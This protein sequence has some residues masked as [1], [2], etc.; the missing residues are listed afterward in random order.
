MEEF[1]NALANLDWN[2]NLANNEFAWAAVVGG[3]LMFARSLPSILRMWA[4]RVF[5][6][7]ITACSE[8]N[9]VF[10]S[11]NAWVV[12]HNIRRYSNNFRIIEYHEDDTSTNRRTKEASN[13]ADENKFEGAWESNG[14]IWAVAPSFGKHLIVVDGIPVVVDRTQEERVSFQDSRR[15]ENMTAWL[16]RSKF[17]LNK[18][19]AQIHAMNEAPQDEVQISL[20]NS[21]EPRSFAVSKVNGNMLVYRDDAFSSVLE[22][23]RTFLDSRER[24]KELN[25]HW[26]RG[27]GFFGPPG[28]G[29]TSMILALASHLGVGIHKFSLDKVRLE[30]MLWAF[31]SIRKGIVVFEDIDLSDSSQADHGEKKDET[32]DGEII[33]GTFVPYA[34]ASRGV[35]YQELLNVLD[36]IETPE[37]I[38]F[39]MTSN[40]RERI[41]KSLM[42]PGRIDLQVDFKLMR[43]KEMAK[44][45]SLFYKEETELPDSIQG[46]IAP[47]ELRMLCIANDRETVIEILI[48][49]FSDD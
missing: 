34:K 21:Y 41:G 35:D 23:M 13:A 5:T 28:T 42:R 9:S 12:S 49:D 43:R 15:T 37:G 26:H 17:L 14:Q 19:V 36:G 40:H 29:K 32:P 18:F 7:R 3:L 46:E 8:D 44:Y 22:D 30:Q 39:I 16:P 6:Y 33:D 45:I 27:Y 31:R 48:K 11:F 1:R 24:Y 38:I 2:A 4:I 10:Q 47:A 20:Y 25:L